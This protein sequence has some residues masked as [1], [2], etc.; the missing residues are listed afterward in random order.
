MKRNARRTCSENDDGRTRFEWRHRG[1]PTR[2]ERQTKPRTLLRKPSSCAKPNG[3]RRRSNPPRGLWRAL[4]PP[5]KSVISP[6]WLP[7]S[8]EARPVP[9][10][11]VRRHDASR[12]VGVPRPDPRSP[13]SRSR[14]KRTQQRPRTLPWKMTS[15]CPLL[16]GKIH[17]RSCSRKM[18]R[19]LRPCRSH[20]IAKATI[21]STNRFGGILLGRIFPRFIASRPSPWALVRRTCGRQLNWLVSSLASGRNAPTRAP[22]TPKPAPS[23]RC[24][25]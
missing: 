11:L 5:R 18:E 4:R 19:S 17:G 20:T 2:R 25:R 16:P 7:I 15:P 12:A 9:S 22:R 21:K 14:P 13:R 1:R 10:T 6:H 24:V 8:K 3:L 23:G